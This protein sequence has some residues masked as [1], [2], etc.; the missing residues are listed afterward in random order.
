MGRT[1]KHSRY[2]SDMC[3]AVTESSGYRWQIEIWQMKLHV[4]VNSSP[5][6]PLAHFPP[7]QDVEVNWES[8]SEK[9]HGLRWGQF[10]VKAAHTSKAKLGIHLPLPMGRQVFGHPQ[11]SRAPS[12]VMVTWEDKCHRSEHP[13]PTSFFFP[14]VLC[15]KHDHY[16]VWN[17]PLVR[18]G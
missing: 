3:S 6:Q 13:S 15:A 7:C 12:H 5:T 1:Y 14:S 17:A 11:E 4:V 18:W 8:K 10:K 2:A 16:M 9:T